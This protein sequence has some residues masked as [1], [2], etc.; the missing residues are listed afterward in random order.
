MKVFI[1]S[2]YKDLI[3]YRAAAIRAV[4][5]TNYQAG[6]MEIFGARSEEPVDACLK[7]VEECEIFIG[8]YA[9][10]YGF[11]PDGS[12]ISITEME[13]LH[14]KGQ[15]KTIYCFLLDEENQ[16]WL[17]KWID[18]E[19]GKSKLRDLKQRVQKAL[20]C[21]YFTTP[22]DLRAKVANALSHFV[23]NH[24]DPSVFGPHFPLPKP[25]G[26]SLPREGFFVGRDAERKIIAEALSPESRTWGALIDGPG[27]IGKTAL[28]IKAAHE[29]PEGLFERKIF[30]SAKVRELTSD[31]EKPLTDFTRPTYLAMLDELGKELGE[32]NLERLAPD[33]RP[34]V[35]RL[36]LADKRALIV[37][38]NLETLPEEE[39]TRLFQF[40]SRLPDGNK[41]IV[42]SRRRTDVDA[43][44][45]RL[46]RLSRDEA[47]ELIAE[48]AKKYQ[49]LARASEKERNDLYSMTH[50]NPLLI[51]WIA[52]QLGRPGSQCRTIADACAF[53][54]K[55]PKG[56]DPLEYIFGDLLEIFTENETLV[57]A[58]LT[59]FS[60]PAKLQWLSQMAGL[61][62]RAAETALEDLA[63]RAILI[64]NLEAQ[65][66][67]LPPLAAR[68][69]KTCRSE[70]VS[71][72]GNALLKRSYAL[73]MQ[74]GGRDNF[75]RLTLEAEWG[76]ISAA[77]PGMLLGDTKRFQIMCDQLDKFMNYSGRWD[78]RIWLCEQAEKQAISIN[79]KDIA[80]WRSHHAGITYF[81]RNQSTEVLACADRIADH[82]QGS[83][84]RKKAIAIRLR[85]LGQILKKDYPAAITAYWQAL[86]MY[87]SISS[88][89]KDVVV[90][91]NDLANAE[92][93]N[94]DK[95]AAERHYREAIRIS[96][97]INYQEGVA[98]S[99]GNLAEL[100]LD[101]DQWEEAEILS[102]E[103][104]AIAEKI[105]SIEVIAFTS[106]VLSKALLKRNLNLSEAKCFA[107]RS[108][109]IYTHL[110]VLD[111][112]NISQQ[113]LAE[114]EKAMRGE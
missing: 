12:D 36:A 56:N 11:V 86:N 1:S 59:Y 5:G 114:I 90:A 102:R 110:R 24:N 34:N 61:P 3:D 50:G 62:E 65:T 29:A 98:S 106:R 88:E 67:Y 42:T 68:F 2:T 108:I 4:E 101:L 55:A 76:L 35:L 51:R 95:V 48:L 66:F 79:D 71:Q 44:I 54:E 20:V 27:G 6:K 87:L 100:T 93:A 49:K 32:Q 39:R 73:S 58:A 9:L 105:E 107:R 82:W 113:T 60:K 74:Y 28:A 47:M 41:A 18:D 52:G 10:R 78:D 22:D 7:E 69:I 97:K 109:E 46:D 103:A 104:L 30:I 14:A 85:G 64:S 89:S 19:P 43:R 72:T 53:I 63:Y 16:G 38:D 13:Y 83:T 26:N 96:N 84:P 45:V 31:G 21:D 70:V 112:I 15:G 17:T 75:D 99:T 23:A 91:L 8:I 33:E 77:L 80:G 40:L 37:F 57:L 25:T 81:R 92:D 111:E 94:K